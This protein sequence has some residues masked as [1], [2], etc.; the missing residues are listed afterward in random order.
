MKSHHN[1]AGWPVALL[2]KDDVCLAG[3]GVVFLVDTLA[4]KQ[5]HHVGILLQ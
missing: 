4:V 2:G 5:D 1:S 3:A